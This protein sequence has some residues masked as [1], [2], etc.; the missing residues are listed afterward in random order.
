MLNKVILMGRLVRD[1][2]L[3]QTAN[4]IAV[5]KFTVAVN[6]PYQKDKEQQAD[7]INVTAWRGT[8]EFVS[9]YFN[10]GSIIIVEGKLQNN[11]YTDKDGI[12]HYSMV[13]QA[14]NVNFGGGKSDSNSASQAEAELKQNLKSIGGTSDSPIGVGDLSEFEEILSDGETPF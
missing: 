5:C 10:K 7:F 6:R 9:K 3:N 13:V 14:D 12:K 1:P 8:A 2:E 11:D 4:G